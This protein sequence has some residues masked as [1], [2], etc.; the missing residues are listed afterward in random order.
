[1]KSSIRL[2]SAVFQ[3]T[4][5]RT[6]CDLV[7]SANGKT[8]KI[9]SGL[10][11]PFLAH[12]KTAQEQMAKG[13]YSISLE[14]EPG[15]DASWFTKGTVERFVRF[16]STPE[17]LE[18][19]YTL[20]SE[21]LQIEQAIAIQGNSDMALSTVEENPAKPTESIEGSRALPDVNEEKA[22]ILYKPGVHPP[23][24]NGSTAQ[25]GN[26]KVQLL[27][28]LETRKTVLQKEQG[29]A[30]ARAV[31][32]GFD[33]DNISPLMDAS[34]RFK[35]LWRKKHETGQWLEIEAA[36]AMSGRSDFSAM[37]TSGIMLSSV[38]NN[39]KEVREA[40]PESHAELAS[41]S[42]G[43]SNSLTGADEKPPLENQLPPGHQ[44]YIQGQ[45]PHQMFPPWPIHSPP[46]AMPVFQAYPMQGMPYY[47]NYPG[48]SPFFQPP[49][50]AVEVPRMNPGQRMGQK[51]HSMDSS[52]SNIES[53]TWDMDA[54]RT[55]S[56]DDADLEASQSRESRKRGSR[57]GKKQ[58]GT[59]VI[60]NINYIT[61]KGQSYSDAE[62]QS[63]SDSQ[64]DEEDGTS[65]SELKH[66]NSHRS[67]KRKENHIKSTDKANSTDKEEIASGKEA[68]GGH[69]QVFQNFL[70]RDAD[71]DKH[72]V[73]Q[74]MF[75]TE[76]KLHSKRRQSALGEDP[77]SFG[78]QVNGEIQNWGAMDV[79]KISGNMARIPK[80]STDEPMISKRD[81]LMGAIDG[82]GDVL[83]SEINRRRVG[84]RRSS[85]E[86]FMIDRQ[87]QTGFTSSA[88]DLLAVNGFEHVKNNMDR[89]LSQNMDDDSY[90]VTLRST[91]L[92]QVGNDNPI[93]IDSEFPSAT[94]TAEN[95]SNRAGAQVN[96]EPEE[97]SM[98]PQRGAEIGGVG[99]D[100]ALDYEMQVH[101]QGGASQNKRGKE[102]A[103]DVSQGSKKSDKGQKSKLLPDDKKK[104][105]GPIR[106]G[107]PSK[108]SH[109]DEARAR[110]ERLRTYKADLQKVKK[111]KE[112][113]EMKRLEALKMERQKRIAARGAI[114]PAQQTRK[115]VPTKTS[116]SSYKGTKFSDLEP[117]PSSPLQRY[118]VRT[119]SVGSADSQKTSK[120]SRLNVGSH[121]AGNRLSRSVTSL[122]E[123]KKE[124]NGVTG[125]TKASVSRIRRLSEPKMSSSH[126]V[127]SL[128]SR[129]TE[130][131]SKSK[132]KVSDGS[133]SKKLSAI[134]NYDKRKAATLPELKIKTSK[135][136]EGTQ[137][138]SSAKEVTQKGNLTKSS[139][140]SE[141]AEA[142]KNNEKFSHHSE[143]DEN[144]V[145]EK[146]VVM[147]EC[148]KPSV[149]AVQA[150]EESLKCRQIGNH[151]TMEK[152][153]VVSDYAAIC[154]PVSPLMMDTVDRE[155]TESQI[156]EKITSNEVAMGD[157][158]K[159]LP[160]LSSLDIAEKSYQ[161]PYARVSSFENPCTEN[162]ESGKA[163]PV[164]SEPVATS[165]VTVHISD[166]RNLKL[167]KMPEALE[168]PQVKESSKG[169]R[170][171][172]KFGRKNHTS[173]SGERNSES[174]NV[175]I[176]GSEADDTATDTV[177]SNEVHTLKNLISQD[178]TPTADATPQKSSRHFS[179]LSPFRSKTSE[180]K[181]ST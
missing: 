157:V 126:H 41:E 22:I 4:P 150:L 163:A 167:E 137:S 166:A 19:V 143:A 174:D 158:N 114:D 76:N 59:V 81:G 36:E 160:K 144:P 92:D 21:I 118:P 45:F 117:G 94:K 159:V 155:P 17:V 161:A 47:Q 124:N 5:T 27:K 105:V 8:E 39:H 162:S 130:P 48:A 79:Q 181:L 29:M 62:S 58:S 110:A 113:A 177:V 149:P 18:R 54:S 65:A 16:V 99:Y 46:G 33:I 146:T 100:P 34:K 172:L 20:E 38:A 37:N 56:S 135:G 70:L 98:M 74:G 82:Q 73:D 49:Y 12:L 121:L 42:N 75:L 107:K 6:R 156:Q 111:E 147:L 131:V 86:D 24:S 28:V 77:L 93:H 127:S 122:P 133:E 90:V 9:A 40:W 148:E 119:S 7:I 102:V 78:G 97:L 139:T 180:K 83:S 51:R 115:Q 106:R 87:K 116:P 35:E 171:L 60:R 67:S 66:K 10:L 168:K 178:E 109:L 68:D 173:A 140:T 3:L 138:K 30:F 145:I 169:F 96:Y 142:K 125:E 170:R 25:E 64:T 89:R 88:S 57:S 108:L 23:E 123:L 154:A 103:T 71:E 176:N 120:S 15:N 152:T 69:W 80:S 175:S 43:K 32:A 11:N 136:P 26:S 53:E 95:L 61:S 63:A 14:P 101:T 153:T 129:S 50:P 55:R 84:Y 141:G 72:A 31:A 132:S 104:N 151:K 112:E 85:N 165:S 52:N 91:S 13:G 44:E 1:M 134:V 164:N 128:K 2:D 179:L